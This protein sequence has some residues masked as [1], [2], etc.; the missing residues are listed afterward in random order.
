[1]NVVSVEKPLMQVKNAHH[2]NV[3]PFNF[4]KFTLDALFVLTVAHV[5]TVQT[6]AM[7]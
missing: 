3:V 4:I 7:R 6:L 5:G 1:M 2:T